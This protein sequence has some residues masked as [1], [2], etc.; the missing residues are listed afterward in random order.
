M[1]LEES[2]THQNL[3][4]SP[5]NNQITLQLLPRYF[6]DSEKVLVTSGNLTISAFTYS[7]GVAGLRIANDV[8]QIEFLPFQGQQIWRA[9]FYDRNLTMRS[10]FEEPEQTSDY[11][12][13]YGAFLIHC[14][15]IG[16]G[17]PSSQD[18]HGVHGELPNALY[19]D[20][21]LLFGN[22]EE[23]R[24]VSVTGKYQHSVAFSHNYVA[25]PTIT[26]RESSGRI[27]VE[28]DIKNLK[29]SPMEFM[30]LSHINF[31]PID[32]GKIIDTAEKGEDAVRVTHIMNSLYAEG[33]DYKNMIDEFVRHPEEHRNIAP[34]KEFNPEL[35]LAVNAS[36]DDLGWASSM[37]L[38]PDGTSDFVRHRPDQFGHC[39]RWI[40]RSG[41][42]EA[43]GLLLPSTAEPDGYLAERAKGNLLT[44]ET[45]G[46]TR[47]SYECGALDKLETQEL[48][49]KINMVNSSQA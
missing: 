38:H 41:D 45:G 20:V 42:Q 43:L 36:A 23:G 28:M 27:R 11:L 2:T 18:D 25:Q 34:G 3:S 8:G 6:G 39:L 12:S 9:K 16:M 21:Q 40:C 26:V 44:I 5:M 4:K 37:Q 47:F 24:Y 29:S 49:G 31:L 35:V 15:V 7:T 19:R 13:T 30:Y 32:N 46:E 14:G 1:E 33:G 22:D 48:A 10:M 17:A